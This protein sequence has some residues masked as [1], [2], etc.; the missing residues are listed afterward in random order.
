M[1]NKV[2]DWL[3]HKISYVTNVCVVATKIKSPFRYILEYDYIVAHFET[4]DPMLNAEMA[5]TCEVDK[6]HTFFLNTYASITLSFGNY[7][8]IV[9][10][11]VVRVKPYK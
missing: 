10:V 2:S 1:T 6:Y 11:A 3:N 5:S 9:T 4:P 7:T 8:S